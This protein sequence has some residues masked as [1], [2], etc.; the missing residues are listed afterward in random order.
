[1]EDQRRVQ[2]KLDDLKRKEYYRDQV[3]K[4]AVEIVEVKKHATLERLDQKLNKSPR[5]PAN[6]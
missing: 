2:Q 1:M 6:S 3:K 4:R 5:H